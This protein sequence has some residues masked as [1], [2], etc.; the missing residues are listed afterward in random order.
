MSNNQQ[1]SE[2]EAIEND[3]ESETGNNANEDS[4]G[5]A[6][7]TDGDDEDHITEEEQSNLQ[8][9]LID[10]VE[11]ELPNERVTIDDINIITEINTLQMSIAKSTV[12]KN[13]FRRTKPK[14]WY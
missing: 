4:D 3:A 1:P 2:A 9:E 10:N 7:S 12:L 13:N 14:K 8:E 11:E 6:R 5:N